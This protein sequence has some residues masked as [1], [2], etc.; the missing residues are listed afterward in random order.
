MLLDP[1]GMLPA[2]LLPHWPYLQAV[3]AALDG[4]GI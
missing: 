2:H 3:D 4:R 1:P